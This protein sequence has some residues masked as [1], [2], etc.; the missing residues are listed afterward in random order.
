MVGKESMYQQ[1]PCTMF[2]KLAWMYSVTFLLIGILGLV[3]AT[4]TGGL[5]FGIFS[6]NVVFCIVYLISGLLAVL[7]AWAPNDR[8]R[9]YFKALG[10]IYAVVAIAGFVQGDVVFGV[11]AT[12]VTDN[13]LNLVL[14]VVA[15]WAG[16]GAKIESPMPV[17]S[18]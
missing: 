7:A 5:I 12:N 4:S 16:F 13:V 2:K 6:T 11:M 3:P 14:A 8:A 10:I 1:L 18:M 9:L 17:A 15:L